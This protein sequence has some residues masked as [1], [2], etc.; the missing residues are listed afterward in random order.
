MIDNKKFLLGCLA[1][2]SAVVL[3]ACGGGGGGSASPTP[4]T[5]PG[6][7]TSTATAQGNVGTLPSPEYAAGSNELAAF[8]QLNQMRQECGFPSLADNSLL[9]KAT[10]NHLN[11]MIANNS[12][13]H[14][15]TQGNPD[16]TGYAP[17][18]R[19]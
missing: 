19:V 9:D 11:Y 14:Y 7:T 4:A 8:Q 3:S 15:E 17:S 12:W 1:I 10:T 13:S 16:F 5:P 2:S 6:P 18:N